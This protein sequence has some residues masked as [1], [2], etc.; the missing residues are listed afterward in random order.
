MHWTGESRAHRAIHVRALAVTTALVVSVSACGDGTPGF[1]TP[2]REQAD[3]D[4]LASALDKGDLDIAS[5]EAL[6]LADLADGAP[7]EV[8]ADLQALA[9]AVVQLVDLLADERGGVDDAGEMERRRARLNE[10]LAE[11]D[12]RSDRVSE[13]AA[14][15]CGIRLD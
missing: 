14:T 12:Q 8:R 7:P 9:D 10:E 1:C 2:F 3:L 11:L 15:E 6:R 4:A 13:W 5:A